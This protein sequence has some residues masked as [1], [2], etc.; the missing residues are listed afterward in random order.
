LTLHVFEMTA[1]I[2]QEL[3]L[4]IVFCGWLW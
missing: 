2:C 4:Q 3:F 1:D